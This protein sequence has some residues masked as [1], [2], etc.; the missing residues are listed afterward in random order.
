MVAFFA[1]IAFPCSAQ[2]DTL[3]TGKV[4]T[5][6]KMIGLGAT[7]ILDTYLSPEKYTGTELR[8]ISH[9]TRERQG[10]K[11]SRQIV[12]IGDVANVKSRSKDG[13][14]IA[15]MY[16]FEYAWHY[17]WHF[18]GGQLD[19][20]AG[21]MVDFNLGFIYNTRNGNNPGQARAFLNFTPSAVVTYHF[22]IKEKPFALRYEI[23]VPLCGV[24]FSP[25]YGQSYYEIFSRGNYDHNIVPTYFGNAPSLR[26]ML[27]LDFRL[28]KTTFRLGYM[29]D[30][31]QSRVNDLKT[32]VYTH[33][34]VIGVVKHFKILNIRP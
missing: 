34:V 17:N 1:T 24:M 23:G 12:H 22:A 26:N 28:L 6:A 5:N 27:T 18:F 2:N 31:Q 11:W 4:I 15:G 33:A 30:F 21:A 14:E 29:G 8:Y 32:H 25:N 20:K 7:E 3:E 10:R 16:N 13:N 19:V 9:T